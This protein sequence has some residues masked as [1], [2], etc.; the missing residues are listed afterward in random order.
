M[1]THSQAVS[2]LWVVRH[3]LNRC[4]GW[5]GVE[6]WLFLGK[7]F[8]FVRWEHIIVRCCSDTILRNELSIVLE[9]RWILHPL[10]R[11]PPAQR[12]L[13]IA[14]WLN[15]VLV[16]AMSTNQWQSCSIPLFGLILPICLCRILWLFLNKGHLSIPVIQVLLISL[17][18][19][20]LVWLLILFIRSIS[21]VDRNLA[22]VPIAYVGFLA[23]FWHFIL[24][25]WSFRFHIKYLFPFLYIEKLA[26]ISEILNLIFVLNEGRH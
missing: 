1:A 25:L 16:G 26:T 8:K 3:S 11:G 7:V 14:P 23:L 21:V 4:D 10:W 12:W 22:L 13:R 2:T 18:F 19:Q 24:L 17:L 9:Q 20:I 5:I 15:I 6:R